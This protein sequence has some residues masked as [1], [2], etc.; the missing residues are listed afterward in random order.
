MPQVAWKTPLPVSLSV[1]LPSPG[2]R[3]ALISLV[4]IMRLYLVSYVRPP[5]YPLLSLISLVP[6]RQIVS[7]TLFCVSTLGAVP[8]WSPP[9]STRGRYIVD[10]QGNRFKLKAAN[11]HGASG[12]WNGD[13][14]PN[15]DI[16]HHASENSHTLPLGLQY[17]PISDILDWMESVGLNSVRLPFSAEMVHDTRAVDDAWVTA[18]P[19]LRGKTPL[20]VY[21]AVVAA[22]TARGIAVILNNHTIKSRWCCGVNDENERWNESQSDDQWADTWLLMVRRYKDNKRVV[23]ADLYNEVRRLTAFSPSFTQ[24]VSTGPT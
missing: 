22:L 11:W 4:I 17:V 18:N 21:D 2:A 23:G 16:N 3:L 1:P 7:T 5:P 20:E 14:D 24:M 10:A 9:L 8:P 13:G 6:P 12:T 15:L 19:Q